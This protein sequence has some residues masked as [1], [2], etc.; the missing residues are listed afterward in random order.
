VPPLELWA[1]GLWQNFL[2]GRPWPG[3]NSALAIP[4]AT[5]QLLR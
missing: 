1:Y 5:L 4:M 3:E 2:V